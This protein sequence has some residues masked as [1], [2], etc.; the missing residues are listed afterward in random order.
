MRFITITLIVHAPDPRT[1]RQKST[2]ERFQEVIGN[3][4]L[5]EDLG[6][7]GFGVGERHERPFISS[8][9]TVVLSH[10]AAL[11]SRIRLFT[12]VTTLSLLDPVR[13]FEDYATLDHLSGGRLELIIG[14]GNGAAQR[15]LFQVTPEDQ[16]DRNAESYEVFRRLWRDNKIT[17]DTKFRPALTGAEVWPRP[18]QHPIR[19]WHGS[20]THSVLHLHADAG[21]LT[22]AQHRASLELFQS[23]IAPVLRREIPDPP[24]GWGGGPVGDHTA[25]APAA[26]SPAGPARDAGDRAAI[27]PVATTG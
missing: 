3:A 9:P 6:F 15:D 16:W 18:L 17:Y 19:V 8:S 12:A 21:G 1:G 4:R 26:S 7:D 20:A 24:W 27:P 22:D 5:A 10:V 11:T 13:A 23:S 14:K 2:Q 25:P